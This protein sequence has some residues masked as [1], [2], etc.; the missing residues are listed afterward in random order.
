MEVVMSGII[1]NPLRH[2]LEQ[3]GLVMSIRGQ[4]TAHA[5]GA[6]D[7]NLYAQCKL[8][9][10]KIVPFL[11]EVVNKADS[12]LGVRLVGEGVCIAPPRDAFV[13]DVAVCPA[14][15]LSQVI[16]AAGDDIQLYRLTTYSGLRQP[17]GLQIMR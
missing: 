3:I 17:I 11:N 10:D 14:N 13:I 1:P 4:A 2:V 15:Y 6:N 16:N 9:T 12:S 7:D 8:H 5:P